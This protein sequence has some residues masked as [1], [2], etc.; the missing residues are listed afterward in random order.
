MNVGLSVNVSEGLT[1]TVNIHVNK[2]QFK[3]QCGLSYSVNGSVTEC[4]N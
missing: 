4:Q 2:C 3:Y 1:V